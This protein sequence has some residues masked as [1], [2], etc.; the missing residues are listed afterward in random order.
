MGAPPSAKLVMAAGSTTA[1]AATP[2]G[3]DDI[4]VKLDAAVAKVHQYQGSRVRLPKAEVEYLQHVETARDFMTGIL[5]ERAVLRDIFGDG[6]R[7]TRLRSILDSVTFEGE[8]ACDKR[9]PDCVK[10]INSVEQLLVEKEETEEELE[11]LMQLALERERLALKEKRPSLRQQEVH[12]ARKA[13]T[14]AHNKRLRRLKRLDPCPKI[15][16]V[17]D[18]ELLASMEPNKKKNRIW[19]MVWMV[20]RVYLNDPTL[21]V[22]DFACNNMP[23]P[24]RQPQDTNTQLIAPKLVKALATNTHVQHV[25]L[26][27]SNLE[28]EEGRVLGESLKQNSTI[29]ILDVCSNHLSPADLEVLFIGVG[30]SR[31]LEEIRCNNQL[32]ADAG[33]SNNPALEALHRAVKMNT[34]L[35][36][37]GMH[38]TEPHFSNEINRQVMTNRDSIRLARKMTKEALHEEDRRRELD[39]LAQEEEARRL[40]AEPVESESSDEEEEEDEE[41]VDGEE[42]VEVEGQDSSPDCG[43]E[44]CASVEERDEAAQ[45]ASG[46]D[47]GDLSSPEADAAEEDPSPMVVVCAV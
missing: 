8:R 35:F 45:N 28:S 36:R 41:W 32:A 13:Y 12:A 3:F 9:V 1:L 31:S 6:A 43:G 33:R 29:R 27:E 4:L 26:C 19:W 47:D 18:P 15:V 11:R 37:I 34:K 5:K 14:A 2:D 22:L 25:N 20:H 40:A 46:A 42:V 24:T 17:E 10:A 30:A 39:R 38:V 7:T 16:A 44:Q 23:S 21:T